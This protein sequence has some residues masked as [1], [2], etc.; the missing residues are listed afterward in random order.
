M[1]DSVWSRRLRQGLESLAEAEGAEILANLESF[2]YVDGILLWAPAESPVKSALVWESRSVNQDNYPFVML[3]SHCPRYYFVPA[4][5]GMD[6]DPGE[7][8]EEIL[9]QCR[10]L[11]MLAKLRALG[12]SS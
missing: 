8:P 3:I 7:G 10:N 4:L 12:G 11:L 5:A 6:V 2:R 9:I 1:S